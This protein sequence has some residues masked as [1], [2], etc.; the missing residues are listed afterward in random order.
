MHATHICTRG[1][2]RG[3]PL[4]LDEA[5]LEL[6]D[7]GLCDLPLFEVSHALEVE[8]EREAVDVAVEP[9]RVALLDEGGGSHGLQAHRGGGESERGGTPGVSSAGREVN[10]EGRRRRAEVRESF[11]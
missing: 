4:Y 8:E 2:E 7:V 11:C 10:K 9:E 5:P 3:R 1:E 6:V